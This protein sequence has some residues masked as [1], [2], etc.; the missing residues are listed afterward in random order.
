MSDPLQD[1]IGQ[2]Q[3]YDRMIRSADPRMELEID[4]LKTAM[5]EMK[6]TPEDA[7]MLEDVIRD[8][9]LATWKPG[10][11]LPAE[12]LHFD[13][14][15]EQINFFREII[16]LA[17]EGCKWGIPSTG[18]EY[19]IEKTKKQFVLTRTVEHDPERWHDKTK[20]ILALLGWSMVDDLESVQ[21]LVALHG[22]WSLGI[23]SFRIDTQENPATPGQNFPPG[24][25]GQ[26]AVATSLKNG[27]L[28]RLGRQCSFNMWRKLTVVSVDSGT[29]KTSAPWTHQKES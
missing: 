20:M 13:P 17:S 24:S 29:G 7:K 15:E 12:A 4:K 19:R 1:L 3:K 22:T 25:Y 9:K 14:T 26:D 6:V 5:A 10:P 11:S 21:N 16:R 28:L 2:F 23:F 18:H 8:P 27:H